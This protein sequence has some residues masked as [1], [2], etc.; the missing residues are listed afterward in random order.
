M[1]RYRLTVCLPGDARERLEEAIGEAMAP[2]SY[3][4]D[5]DLSHE[6][7]IWDHWRI[8]GGADGLGH[9]IRPGHE[10]DPRIVHDQ[11]LWDG[12]TQPSLPGW[13][14]GG[15]L[16]LLE[17]MP[18]DRAAAVA[19]LVWDGWREVARANP[20]SRPWDDFH[21]GPRPGMDEGAYGRLRSSAHAEYL[22][23]TPVA[24]YREWA[25]GLRLDPAD[26][27]FRPVLVDG[28]RDP[29]GAIGRWT[30]E[31]FA[32]R[33][34]REVVGPC[35]LLT[36]DGWWYEDGDLPVHGACDDPAVCPHPPP[37]ALGAGGGPAYLA[38]LPAD[39]LLVS[40]RCHV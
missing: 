40:V 37:S 39:T 16:G 3:E 38:G 6:L 13:C 28:H 35:N 29:L 22:A 20:P 31:E 34:A 33:G 32:R 30:R 10:A 2:F 27:A 21:P 14:A 12:T 1:A 24:A 9:R 11:P 5:G 18:W 15:P 4:R 26:E 23:Q 7:L 36:L 19:R 8:S 17:R 25:A